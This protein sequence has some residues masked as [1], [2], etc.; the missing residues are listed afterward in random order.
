MLQYCSK[1]AAL[2]YNTILYN[3]IRQYKNNSNAMIRYNTIRSGMMNDMILNTTESTV[4]YYK[5]YT[6]VQDTIFFQFI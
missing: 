2:L 1:N 5:N 4:G 3:V 6:N